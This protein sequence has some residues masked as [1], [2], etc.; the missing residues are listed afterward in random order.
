LTN[1]LDSRHFKLEVDMKLDRV[2]KLLVVIIALLLFG[3]ARGFSQEPVST[4]LG[5]GKITSISR[6]GQ[7]LNVTLDNGNSYDVKTLNATKLG[8][9]VSIWSWN[10]KAKKDKNGNLV[11][12]WQTVRKEKSS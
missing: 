12:V 3:L 7:V 6:V 4:Q 9:T 8:D 10:G 5:K 1:E 2:E 11:G